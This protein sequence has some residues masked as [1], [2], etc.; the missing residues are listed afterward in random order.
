M[1][2]A[3]AKWWDAI[4]G[5]LGGRGPG[6]RTRR[7]SRRGLGLL[8][9]L[10][11]AL[12]CGEVL[13]SAGPGRGTPSIFRSSAA[14]GLIYEGKPNTSTV[15]GA[16][17]TLPPWP[18]TLD[19]QGGRTTAVGDRDCGSIWVLGDSFAF[20]WGVADAEAWPS[21][22]GAS[23]AARQGCSP[24][25]KNWA[26]PGYHLGQI[27]ARLQL[28]A[29]RSRPDLVV[30]HLEEFDGFPDFDFANPLGLPSLLQRSSLFRPLQVLAVHRFDRSVVDDPQQRLA[31]DVRL[32]LR[33]ESIATLVSTL[34][35]RTLVLIEPEVPATIRDLIGAELGG[36]IDLAV[37]NRPGDR[38][39]T[40]PHYSA[41]GNRCI[42]ER[43][44]EELAADAVFGKHRP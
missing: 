9:G 20:G 33:L 23:I 43:V 11:I 1:G 42:A 13:M 8:L 16:G 3:K 14:P 41:R 32:R 34:G 4:V 30:L 21:L 7:V 15:E 28:L 35:L 5:F 22:L 27:E 29:E 38:L 17:T 36:W 39:A 40:D 31:Q 2:G 26:L 19:A 10:G 18:I 6:R 12:L 37:C 24:Q 44:A 25:V